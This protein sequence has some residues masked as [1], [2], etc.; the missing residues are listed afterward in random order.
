MDHHTGF[1]NMF[2]LDSDTL[3]KSPTQT[4]RTGKSVL[5]RACYYLKSSNVHLYKRRDR[6]FTLLSERE[7]TNSSGQ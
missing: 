1:E 7:V 4:T 2:S 3:E 6:G 5:V